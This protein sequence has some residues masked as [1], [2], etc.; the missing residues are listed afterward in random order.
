[1]EVEQ[2][3]MW[4]EQDNSEVE[5]YLHMLEKKEEDSFQ[6][7]HLHMHFEV[8]AEMEVADN[9]VVDWDYHTALVVVVDHLMKS[10]VEKD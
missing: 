8:A 6:V 4:V 3:W 2:C 10:S 1:M 7:E 9:L 5:H